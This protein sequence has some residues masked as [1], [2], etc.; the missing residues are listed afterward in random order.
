MN[1]RYW[2]GDGDTLLLLDLDTGPCAWVH[3]EKISS[4]PYRPD[5]Y[6]VNIRG[7]GKMSESFESPEEAMQ[8]AEATYELKNNG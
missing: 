4:T 8:F 7:A 6:T 5:Y 1:V 3:R 2:T